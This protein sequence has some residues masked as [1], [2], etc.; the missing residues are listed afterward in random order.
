MSKEENKLNISLKNIV[1][2]NKK[3][4]QQLV[5][6]TAKP[7]IMKHIG[8]GTPYTKSKIIEFINYERTQLKLSPYVRVYWTYAVLNNNDVIG[9]FALYRKNISNLK[10]NRNLTQNSKNQKK[11]L[12]RKSK[13][14]TKIKTAPI[15]I[16]M[17][18]LL[19]TN[20]Q[21]KGI[22]GI[23][24]NIMMNILTNCYFTKD[25]IPVDIIS[26][27]NIDNERS[28]ALQV[29]SGLEYLGTYNDNKINR[30]IYKWQLIK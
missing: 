14:F 26:I 27:V 15:T 3:Q 25:T 10:L 17:R 4:I 8:D 9:L 21:G 20:Y 6:I 2:L 7:E 16:A 30:N 1:Y 28:N 29:K 22:G 12:T 18:R 19:D 11:N 24:F 23:I 13:S 5:D